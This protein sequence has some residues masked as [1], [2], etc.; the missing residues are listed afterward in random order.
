MRFA[1]SEVEPDLMVRQPQPVKGASWDTA[2]IPILIIEIL[3]PSTRRR[4]QV[5]KRSLYMDAGVA[6]Y[7]LVDP[8]RQEITSVL[9]GRADF[10]TQDEMAWWPV[11]APAALIFEVAQVFG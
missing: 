1:G 4:D 6:E 10:V 11:D 5:Q 3:A 8:E 2:P 7:W 9:A